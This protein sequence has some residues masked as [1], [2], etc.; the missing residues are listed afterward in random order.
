MGGVWA[1]LL[2]CLCAAFLHDASAIHCYSC[3]HLAFSPAPPP[4]VPNFYK[5]QYCRDFSKKTQVYAGDHCPNDDKEYVCGKVNGTYTFDVPGSGTTNVQAI[6]RRCLVKP[7]G[8]DESITKKV[9]FR[10]D[11]QDK[12]SHDI[13]LIGGE[14]E[15][16]GTMT[17]FSGEVCYCSDNNC[18]AATK[19]G[20][21]VVF[22]V[23]L[24]T[25]L[26][27]LMN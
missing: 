4:D 7:A 13:S 24:A 11:A 18:N 15:G 16:F 26:A 14:S 23:I 5:N 1:V 9:C 19:L 2:T 27:T 6:L 17:R 21:S 8:Y 25:V 3:I 22:T 12:A 10:D 20:H